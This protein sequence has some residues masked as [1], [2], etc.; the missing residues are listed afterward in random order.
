M[1]GSKEQIS[2]LKLINE[3]DSKMQRINTI[4]NRN[5]HNKVLKKKAT[6]EST[7]KFKPVDQLNE[8]KENSSKNT[9]F[10]SIVVLFTTE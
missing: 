8:G 7:C 6:Y 1:F 5:L 4:Q 3:K 10:L 2:Q 9:G